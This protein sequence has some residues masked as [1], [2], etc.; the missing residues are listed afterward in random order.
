MA[1]E[2]CGAHGSF[3]CLDCAIVQLI[4]QEAP[5]GSLVLVVDGAFHKRTGQAGVG[6]VLAREDDESVLAHAAIELTTRNSTVAEYQA[7]RRG[8]LWAPVDTCWS[9]CAGAIRRAR[10]DG[11]PARWIPDD[12]RDPL[13]NLAHRLSNAACFR[14]WERRERLWIPGA[15]W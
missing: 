12:L 5:R 4:V 15:V 6:L 13:H 9:D 2:I 1:C 8:L 7:I 10:R 14:N 11:L 3:T